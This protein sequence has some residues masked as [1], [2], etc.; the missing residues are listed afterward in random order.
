[1]RMTCCD[2]ILASA[3]VLRVMVVLVYAATLEA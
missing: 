3:E 1:L 2:W